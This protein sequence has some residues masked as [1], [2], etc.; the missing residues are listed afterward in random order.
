M[1]SVYEIV[2]LK[3]EIIVRE[4]LAP[5]KPNSIYSV[6][7]WLQNEIGSDTQEN[8]VMFCL[9]TQNNL[10]CYSVI[11]KGTMNTTIAHIRDIFQR[12]I[13]SNSARL[14]VAHNH[15]SNRAKPSEADDKMTLRIKECGDLFGIEL[16]DHIIVGR[17]T[18]FS[19]REE[20]YIK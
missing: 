13:L 18:Y 15:P 19:Y 10:N 2:K 9:D 11:F 5:L 7:K 1:N 12:A 8:F 4:D 16:L 3:Q 14:I 20:G 6:A 17:D